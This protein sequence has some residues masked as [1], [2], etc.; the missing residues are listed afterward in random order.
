MS[1]QAA[2]FIDKDGTLIRDIPFN[3]RPER[4]ELLPG[5]ADGLRLLHRAGFPLVI[6]SN[7]SGVARGHFD[8]E[9]LVGVRRRIETLMAEIE[10]PLTAFY[11]C[12]HHPLGNVP[13]Y[14]IV[15][16]CRKP[17]PGMLQRAARELSIDLHRSWVIG[18]ILDDVEA[19]HS[20]G[21]R[22]I[23]LLGGG[24]TRW[25]LSAARDPDAT[26]GFGRSRHHDRRIETC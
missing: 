9:Q 10:V 19:A 7:Q 3:V 13:G 5:A 16:D 15:C 18:D 4:I 25:E 17:K 12:P 8:E 21:C 23:L 24:E 6:I 1:G 22:A 2:V 20:A 11:Y 14:A 26:A